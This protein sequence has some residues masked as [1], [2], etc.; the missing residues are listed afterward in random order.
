MH[1]TNQQVLQM[2]VLV[3]AV[4]VLSCTEYDI[5][6]SPF[7]RMAAPLTSFLGFTA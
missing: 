4:Q 3:E 2:T 1:E 5:A 7:W 6:T